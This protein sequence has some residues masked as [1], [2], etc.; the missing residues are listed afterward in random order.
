[1]YIKTEIHNY[2]EYYECILKD[3]AQKKAP[4]GAFSTNLLCLEVV[5]EAHSDL[6]ERRT[7][8]TRLSATCIEIF[9]S[10]TVWEV[11]LVEHTPVVVQKIGEVVDNNKCSSTVL[12]VQPR[13][14]LRDPKVCLSPRAASTVVTCT[15][16]NQYVLEEVE[17]RRESVGKARALEATKCE[18]IRCS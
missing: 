11:R 1:M 14:L 17:V 8:D 10:H 18:A 13:Q 9:L 4:N 15:R 2:R 7:T 16:L 6:P 3:W 5:A 12:L